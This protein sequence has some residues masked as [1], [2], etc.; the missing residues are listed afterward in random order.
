MKK[1][2]YFLT[3]MTKIQK[4]PINLHKIEV[5]S[6]STFIKKRLLEKKLKQ[7]ILSFITFYYASSNLYDAQS[8]VGISV[9][10]MVQNAWIKADAK[11]ALVSNGMLWSMAARRIL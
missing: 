7:P 4:K 6:I 3:I 11:R 2:L 1:D 5:A 9:S 8:L 10:L